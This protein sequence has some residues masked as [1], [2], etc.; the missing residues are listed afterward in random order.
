ME[1]A[2][3]VNYDKN[4]IDLYHVEYQMVYELFKVYILLF[5]AVTNIRNYGIIKW[6][7]CSH[8]FMNQF[9]STADIHQ[10]GLF[11]MNQAKKV[12]I[13]FR[14]PA[15]ITWLLKVIWINH[16]PFLESHRNPFVCFLIA[17]KIFSILFLC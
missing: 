13:S 16:S 7:F 17:F 9:F 10:K 4:K 5:F 6:K 11:L 2:Y 14:S 12:F 15:R 3:W 1:Y 8:A